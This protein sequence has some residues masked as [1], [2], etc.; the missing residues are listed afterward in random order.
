MPFVVKPMLPKQKLFRV[1]L[2]ISTTVGAFEC[3]WAWFIFLGFKTRWVDVVICF[4]IPTKLSVVFGFVWAVAF[5]ALC[6]LNFAGKDGVFPLLVILTLEY[7]WVH[8]YPSN[9]SN[10]SSNIEVSIDK[11]LSLAPTL[12]VPNVYSDNGHI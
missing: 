7:P 8:V 10:V 11:T 4:T 1:C 9:H 5:Y 2:V 3:M 6:S 12:N